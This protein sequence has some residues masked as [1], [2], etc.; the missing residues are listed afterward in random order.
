MNKNTDHSTLTLPDQS[1]YEQAYGL[2]LKLAMEELAAIKDFESLSNKSGSIHQSE[3][4]TQSI[5]LKYLNKTYRISL[6]D[7]SV[8]QLNC[9]NPVILADKILILHYLLRAKGTP[10]FN[11]WIAFQELKEGASY[12]PSF[13]K[14]S[15][16]PLIDYFGRNP[17]KLI[18]VSGE[19][20]G[21]KN[22]IGDVSVTIPAF[23]RLPVTY[24]IWRGDDEFPPNA[25]I[26]FD[27]SVLD[28]LPAEDVT[29]L[30]QTITWRLVKSVQSTGFSR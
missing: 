28:Y 14:R 8:S 26:L 15:V 3:G 6:P 18:D 24:V 20:G 30:C 23:A 4:S 21:I 13:V 25:N 19:L 9:E 22:D 2:S 17:E 5:Q 1:N 10:L 29:V 12:Y 7:I 27:K 16:K 11:Q